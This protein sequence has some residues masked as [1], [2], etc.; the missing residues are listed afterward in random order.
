MFFSLRFDF[1]NPAMA[2]TSMADRYRAGIE[3]TEWADRLGAVAVTISEH[4][5]SPDGYLPSPLTMMAALA[6]RTRRVR[7]MVA[8]LIAPFHDP[9]RLAEDLV[10][11]DHLS[12]GRVD[13]V[14]GSGYVPEELAMFGIDPAARPRLVEQTV[15]VLRAAFAGEPF[16]YQGR[17]IQV[18]PTPF[19]PTGPSIVLGGSSPAAAKRAARIADGFV[20][21]VPEVWEHYRSEVQRLGRPDP[22]PY[23]GGPIRTVALAEDPEA[24]WAAM[25]PYFL[26]ET[27]A[28]GAWQRASGAA[29]PYRMV[30]DLDELRAGDQYAVLTPEAYVEELRQAPLPVSQLHPL[31][32]GMPVDL[33][34]SSL[35]LFEHKVLPAFR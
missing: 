27:N 14:I 13:V 10:V 4:H 5:G 20:P 15:A 34:W 7:L 2:G 28:Y 35:E 16:E 26:H 9:V 11:L 25:G 31:C 33:A 21:S 19:R 24:G 12:E 6:A 32:G 23:P 3:M 29:S 17:T 1:R 18:T 30:R 8:A 22:G